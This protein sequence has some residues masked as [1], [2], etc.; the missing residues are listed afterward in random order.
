ML[1]EDHSPVSIIKYISEI[2]WY[3]RFHLGTITGFPHSFILYVLICQAGA[4]RARTEK[5]TGT[6]NIS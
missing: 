2:K 3:R 1:L 5:G 6:D 4:Q